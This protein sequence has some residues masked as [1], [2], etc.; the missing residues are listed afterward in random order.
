MDARATSTPWCHKVMFQNRILDSFEQESPIIQ[1]RFLCACRRQG[2]LLNFIRAVLVLTLLCTFTS[3]PGHA[4]KTAADGCHYCRANCADLGVLPDRRHC[5]PNLEKKEKARQILVGYA[6]IVDGDSIRINEKNIRLQGIDAPEIRQQC[7]I[8]K[9]I[10]PCG[11]K[12]R[13]TLSELIG[14]GFIRCIWSEKDRYERFLATCYSD[15]QNVNAAMVKRG[16]A[17]AYR[18]YSMRYIEEEEYAK[19]GG[20]GLWVTNFVEPWEWR[21]GKR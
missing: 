17:L 3:A 1:V 12:A 6:E 5:H 10:E 7:K 16:M 21:K 18:R 8:G 20:L 13:E 11:R 14:D 15:H 4:G 2:R 9:H 19:M